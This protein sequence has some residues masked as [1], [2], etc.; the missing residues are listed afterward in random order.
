MKGRGQVRAVLLTALITILLLSCA[1]VVM[2]K[3]E[4][5]SAAFAVA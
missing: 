2:D 5:S 1:A 4:I 3:T